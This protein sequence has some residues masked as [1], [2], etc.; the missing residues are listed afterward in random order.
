M[1]FPDGSKAHRAEL[2]LLLL[3]LLL[4]D[5]LLLPLFELLISESYF[6]LLL[7]ALLLPE[8]ALAFSILNC[9]TICSDFLEAE[10]DEWEDSFLFLLSSELLL[11]PR[12]TS[13]NDGRHSATTSNDNRYSKI[14]S[15]PSNIRGYPNATPSYLP[16]R[17]FVLII[18]HHN[19]GSDCNWHK[20][21]MIDSSTVHIIVLGWAQ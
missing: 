12:A 11:S 15:N 21:S 4:F 5:D 14:Q 13:S 16:H 9:G 17:G 1:T 3:L 6:L 20:F 8:S 10:A 7:L 18:V 19:T 2:E